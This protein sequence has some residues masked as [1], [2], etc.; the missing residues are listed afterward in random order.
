MNLI[1]LDR[2]GVINYDSPE[3]IK[4]PA[5]WVPIPGSLQAIADLNRAGYQIAV[6]TNQSGIARGLYDIA[7][8]AAIHARMCSELAALGGSIAKIA[9]CPHH[10]QDLCACR[11]PKPGLL[12]QI[13]EHFGCSLHNVPFIGDQLTDVAA[14]QHVDAQ[15]ILITRGKAPSDNEHLI[16][17]PQYPN[18]SFAVKAILEEKHGQT[19]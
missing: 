17:V 2:D 14:A 1:I 16:D 4:S 5:E 19:T 10:P 18:L 3:Y 6:A 9:Y 12:L 11:K 8:L 7:T 15:A 13:A